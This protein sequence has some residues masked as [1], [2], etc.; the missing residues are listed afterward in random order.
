MKVGFIDIE[1]E[2]EDIFLI[3][4][5]ECIAGGYLQVGDGEMQPV[6]MELDPMPDNKSG[7]WS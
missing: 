1:G 4:G 6:W 7:I 5:D 3:K 2:I